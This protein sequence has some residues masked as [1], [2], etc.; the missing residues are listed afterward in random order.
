[1][2]FSGLC[3]GKTGCLHDGSTLAI[4]RGV[5]QGDVISPILFN[6][7]LESAMRQVETEVAASLMECISVRMNVLPTSV[8]LTTC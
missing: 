2:F 1:M 4:Q 8:I 6:A 5:K 3:I 7:T